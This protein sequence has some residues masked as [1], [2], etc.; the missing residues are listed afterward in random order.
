MNA[1]RCT[2]LQRC[3][4][5]QP[6]RKVPS[7][8]C[9]LSLS[10][11]SFSLSLYSFFPSLLSLLACFIPCLLHCCFA[12]FR[13]SL[14]ASF[15]PSFLPSAVLLSSVPPMLGCVVFPC[16]VRLRNRYSCVR[17]CICTFS[18]A[19]AEQR[20]RAP[21][22]AGREG[23]GLGGEQAGAGAAAAAA[24]ATAAAAAVEVRC[25]LPLLSVCWATLV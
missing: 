20:P 24:T 8:S 13:R 19:L 11:F 2:K 14:L 15:L 16:L 25:Q 3:V 6:R 5:F 23:G 21:M 9:C 10:Q 17:L 4:I 7:L 12:S 18:D 1:V 22:A